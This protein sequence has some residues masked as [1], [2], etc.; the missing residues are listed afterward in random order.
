MVEAVARRR[1]TKGWSRRLMGVVLCAFFGLG[2]ITGFSAPGRALTSSLVASARQPWERLTVAL[3]P[4][5]ALAGG[6]TRLSPA[7]AASDGAVAL[8]ERTDGFYAL[9]PSGYLR[10]PLS[11]QGLDDLPVLSGPGAA[12]APAQA[13]VAD[14]K[15]AVRAEARL[16]ALVSEMRLAG[17]NTASLF[18]EGTRIEVVLR[19]DRANEELARAE[20]VMKLWGGRKQWLAKLDLTVP[21]EA[22]VE[23][24]SSLFEPRPFRHERRRTGSAAARASANVGKRAAAENWGIRGD[25]QA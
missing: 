2:V 14:A 21:G 10:G 22:I 8:I 16:S 15:I 20:R 1:E 19:L 11:P 25:L 12:S 3:A 4:L 17:D 9:Y 18:I 5:R 7:L 13:L 24:R 23:P 6:S